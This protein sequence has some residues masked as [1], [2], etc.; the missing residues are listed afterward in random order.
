M[1]NFQ[2]L[3]NKLLDSMWFLPSLLVAFLIGLAFL[4]LFLDQKYNFTYGGV[5]FGLFGG[6]ADAARGLLSSIAGSL[7]A[8]I[9]TAFS[10]TLVAVQQASN[11]Y[12]P[13]VMRTFS[14]DKGNQIVLGTYLGT[15]IYS[16]LVLRTVRTEAGSS[17]EYVPPLSISVAILLALICSL[18][19][20]YFI[21]HIV[22]SLR[23]EAIISRIHQDLISQ[24][25]SM[26]PETLGVAVE[27][28]LSGHEL[29]QK[30]RN[31][32][33][34]KEV[35]SRQAGFLRSIDQ[36]QLKKFKQKGAVLYLPIQVGDFV[37]YDQIMMEVSFLKKDTQLD[38]EALRKALII[39]YPRSTEKDP[40]FAIRM[41][42]D[43]ALRALSPGINDPTTAE[44]CLVH[45]GD[46]VCR[47][48]NR[49][50][51]SVQRTFPDN[52][53]VFIFNTPNW[54]IYI[55]K[56]FNQIRAAADGNF[57]VTKNILLQLNKISGCLMSV[58]RRE[59]INK[60]VLDIRS[61]VG[62]QNFLKTEKQ[63]LDKIIGEITHP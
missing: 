28:E 13:R 18:L 44:Y 55:D 29:F 50:F 4:V 33:L 49:Q 1:L 27:N 12:S 11:Q 36:G 46:A 54:D 15:F 10:I 19:L 32:S 41:L 42:T 34:I 63:E 21:N 39:G 7:I 40:L 45:L 8:V 26:F 22:N 5:I 47:L 16:L 60:M 17:P 31:H 24:I 25:D 57:H 43:I 58:Q 2:D 9:S 59:P 20:I 48:A 23:S 14:S 62:R 53:V 30:R 38:E 35:R 61:T 51:P 37:A 3:K 6:T 52:P 56:S